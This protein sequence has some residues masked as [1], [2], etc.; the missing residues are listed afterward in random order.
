MAVSEDFSVIHN[1]GATAPAGHSVIVFDQD[2]ARAAEVAA[3]LR[4]LDVQPLVV[5]NGALMRTL[6][7]GQRTPPSLMI[8]DTE[9]SFDYR[10]FGAALRG[11]LLGVPVIA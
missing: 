8:G 11:P 6:V 3:V 10:E 9:E 7:Q 5:D 2:S 4:F 1:D